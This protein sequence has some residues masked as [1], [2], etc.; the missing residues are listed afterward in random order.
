MIKGYS[1]GFVVALFSVVAVILGVLAALKL[2]QTLSEAL[3]SEGGNF[4]KWAP[5]ISYMIVF[6]II[7]WLV[8]L[9][10]KLIQKALHAVALGWLNK[11]SG[12][13]LY[14]FL[15]TFVFSSFLWLL[16]RM[17]LLNN[18]TKDASKLYTF[19]EPLAPKVFT[20]IGAILPFAKTI[21]SD[22]SQFF[23]QVNQ[24]IK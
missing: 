9:G 17:N 24:K 8:R 3:F 23:D 5:I 13:V 2:S 11:L 20:L 1:K 19:I 7:V 10:A 12:A 14:G 18:D 21:F 6:V 16:S 4:G 22:L 15:L